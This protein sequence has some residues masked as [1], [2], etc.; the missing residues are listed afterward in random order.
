MFK[1][2][3]GRPR[4]VFHVDEEREGASAHHLRDRSIERHSKLS[5]ILSIFIEMPH[6]YIH[7]SSVSLT[8][9]VQSYPTLIPKPQHF[10]RA[11]P[12]A[13]RSSKH[14][15]RPSHLVHLAAMPNRLSN[16]LPNAFLPSFV[17]VI[18]SLFSSARLTRYW[19][20]SP[21]VP[22]TRY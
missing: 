12:N 10:S 21:T 3:G 8:S 2:I 13:H 15:A 18:A 6:Y 17:L 19:L 7:P 5:S 20:H 16:S 4:R 11:S 22:Q 14:D 9:C 1:E